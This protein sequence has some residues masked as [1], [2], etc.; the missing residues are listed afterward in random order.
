MGIGVDV[1]QVSRLD[2][3]ISR[4]PAMLDR[5]F[6]ATERVRADGTALGVESLAARFAVKEAVAKA[7][8]APAGMEWH[9]CEVLEGSSGEPVLRL[10]GTVEA[11]AEAKGIT[12]WHVSMSHDGGIAFATVIAEDSR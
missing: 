12:T 9:H 11:A 3:S 6:T 4:K 10:T 1:V 5:L 8:G 2:E 7:L